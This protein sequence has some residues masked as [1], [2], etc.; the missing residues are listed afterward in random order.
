MGFNVNEVY[1]SESNWLKAADLQKQKHRAV[2]S[3]VQMREMEQDGKKQRKLE[4]HFQGKDKTLLLNKTNCD[5][6]SYIH[7]PDTDAW[8]GK[9]I[10]LF[11]TMV[12]FGGRSVEAIRI[13]MPLQEAA[14]QS[15]QQGVAQGYSADGLDDSDIP[16]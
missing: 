8:L 4:L 1:A 15:L 9:E 11:P 5:T 10:V 2:I 3:D 7:G 14:P 6:I 16:F 12:D 13:E